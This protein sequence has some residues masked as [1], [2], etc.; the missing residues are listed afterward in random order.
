MTSMTMNTFDADYDRANEVKQFDESKKGV[1]GLFDSGLTTIPRF[2]I[3]PP[4]TLSE[5]KLDSRA[6]PESIS[7]PVIDL[8]DR[9][10]AIVDQISRAC[11]KFGFFQIVNHGIALETLERTVSSIK[12]FH[13]QPNEMKAP[14]YSREPAGS[15]RYFSNVDLFY[16]KAAS[17]MDTLYMKVEPNSQTLKELPEI[18]RKEMVDWHREVKVLV[19]KLTELMS[20]GLGLSA[21]KL[22]EY[23]CLEGCTMVGNYYPSCPQPHLT[24]GNASHTDGGVLTVLIQDQIGGLQVQYGDLWVDVK[25]VPGAIVIN[26]GD[27]LQIITND[28]YKSGLHRVLANSSGKSRVSVAVFPEPGKKDGLFGPLLELTSPNKPALYKHFTY[29]EYIGKF[30]SSK[31]EGKTM[32]DG[33]KL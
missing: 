8:S 32:I 26:V 27:L 11:R 19:D 21:E 31:V 15:I 14:L 9:H 1:K 29:F 13:D 30:F 17:W 16:T 5:L 18:C 12:A 10:S 22:K 20:E 3:H 33:Y 7:I 2:F 4:E 24:M 6:P 25:P 23:T 28:E